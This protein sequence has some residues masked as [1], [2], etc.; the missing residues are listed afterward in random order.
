[1]EISQRKPSDT[2]LF[3]VI[4]EE[5]KLKLKKLAT[6]YRVSMTQ[7]ANGL[8]D[9]L[10]KKEEQKKDKWEVHTAGPDDIV[11]F[12]TEIEALRRAN[13]TNKSYLKHRLSHPGEE[14]L[15]VATVGRTSG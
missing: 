8:I 5:R 9:D 1:M 2:T 12:D 3:V 6:G 7:I 15:M 11:I 10:I 4:G 14:V 13:G